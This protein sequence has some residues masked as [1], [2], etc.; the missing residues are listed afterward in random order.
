MG[1]EEW[2]RCTQCCLWQHV[3]MWRVTLQIAKAAT[4]TSSCFDVHLVAL[5]PQL[6]QHAAPAPAPPPSAPLLC[7]AL[8]LSGRRCCC[9][10]P[11]ASCPA[12]KDTFDVQTVHSPRGNNE[13]RGEGGGSPFM[14]STAHTHMHMRCTCECVCVCVYI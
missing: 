12:A 13:G 1:R 14:L 7:L 3:I 10:C 5:A 2:G 6:E 9:C 11:L 8:P 4:G